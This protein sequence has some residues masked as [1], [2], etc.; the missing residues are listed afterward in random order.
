MNY[1]KNPDVL[2][3]IRLTDYTISG[4]FDDSIVFP[5]WVDYL[6]KIGK[7]SFFNGY[8]DIDGFCFMIQ[9]DEKTECFYKSGL[10]LIKRFHD[11]NP[12]IENN[13]IFLREY[14]SLCIHSVH[15]INGK[16]GGLEC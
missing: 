6:V 7:L 16:C 1:V 3:A 13:D 11:E 5:R 2:E 15:C 12:F 9:F 14:S 4:F 10:W 8:D